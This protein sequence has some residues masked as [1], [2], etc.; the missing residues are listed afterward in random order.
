MISSQEIESQPLGSTKRFVTHMEVWEDEEEERGSWLYA[1][2]ER[3]GSAK[4]EKGEKQQQTRDLD[5]E[6]MTT[7]MARGRRSQQPML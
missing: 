1:R 7:M 4:K 6:M 3:G 2:A 5:S